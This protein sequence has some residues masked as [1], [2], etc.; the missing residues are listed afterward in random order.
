[1]PH[2]KDVERRLIADMDAE[3]ILAAAMLII[4]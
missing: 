4:E 1:M 3:I 2:V